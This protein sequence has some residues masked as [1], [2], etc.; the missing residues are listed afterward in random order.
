MKK[1]IFIIATG[2][3][4]IA[5]NNTGKQTSTQQPSTETVEQ[6]SA[7][8]EIFEKEWKLKEL[9]GKAIALDSTFKKEAFIFFEK[10]SSRVSGNGGCN[11]FGGNF[12]LEGTDGI[13]IS[14]I[15]GTMMACPNME[16]EGQFFEN[17]KNAKTYQIENN[18]LTLFND[19]KEAVAKLE[20]GE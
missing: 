16:T 5:C 9:D 20:A 8:D 17:L 6:T 13:T 1:S 3:A 19:K 7:S 10:E 2:F 12:K 18:A 15:A 11:S 14:D 4:V